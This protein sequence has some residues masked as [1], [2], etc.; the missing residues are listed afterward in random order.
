MLLGSSISLIALIAAAPAGAASEPTDRGWVRPELEHLRS[1]YG[2]RWVRRLDEPELLQVNPTQLVPPL[3]S[4]DGALVYAATASGVLYGVWTSSGRILW[5]RS[6]LGQIG[7][8]LG[9]V[10]DTLIAG[11]AGALYGLEGYS[12]KEQW[13]VDLGG[14]VGGPITRTGT[15]TAIVPVRPNGYV[16][17][18]G[19]TGKVLWRVKR[20]KPEGI[21]VRGQAQAQVDRARGRVFLGS[22]DG[23]VYAVSLQNGETLWAAKISSPRPDEPFA[24]VDTQPLLLDGGQT[25]IAA[26]YNGGIAALAADNGRIL[27]KKEELLHLTHLEQVTGAPWLVGCVGDGQVVGI[28]PADGKIRWRYKLR[29]DG[30]PTRALALDHG[31][32]GVGSSKGPFAVLESLSGRPIQLITPGSGLTAQPHA[33][34]RELAVWTNKGHLLGLR[35]GEGSIASR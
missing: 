3:V 25:V 28:D 32:V 18:D 23:T 10:G 1:V 24:D 22:A 9:Q 12:G 27:W 6:D 2:V 4:N 19:Y 35:F 31:L 14:I 20:P 21:S 13:R 34:G 8:G 16:A 11:A 17:I 33:K 15:T 26:S 5:K 7:R 29:G 30:V